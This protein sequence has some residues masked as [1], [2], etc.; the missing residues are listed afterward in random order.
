MKKTNDLYGLVIF[1]NIFE[2]FTNIKYDIV[3]IAST[4]CK[5]CEH[6]SDIEWR[7]GCKMSVGE[8][9]CGAWT[10]I[11]WVGWWVIGVRSELL[12]YQLICNI[13]G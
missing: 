3:A 9:E 7:F 2:T 12:W 4:I 11:L 5:W 6:R 13:S 10:K 8:K 1:S